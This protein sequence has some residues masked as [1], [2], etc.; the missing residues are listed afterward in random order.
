[1]HSQSS[2]AR[3]ASITVAAL[4]TGYALY[5]LRGILTPLAL[6][7]FL[8]VMVDG[9]ARF[10]DKRVKI[11]PSA[12][13]LPVALLVCGLAL[14]ATILV[15]AGNA[16]A[17]GAQLL[18]AAPRFNALIAQVAGA[19]GLAVPPTIQELV[20]QLNPVAYVGTIANSLQSFAGGAMYVMI[21]LGF[22]IASRQGFEKKTKALFPDVAEREH[23][24][25]IF[26]RIRDG[27]ERYLWIQTVTG[28][29]IALL[30]WGVMAAVGL[31]NSVF[32][33]FVI[34]VV[35]YIPVVG[36]VIAGFLPPLFSLVQFTTL[37]QA[38]V[39]FAGLQVIL[40]AVGNVMLPRMQRDNLNI[41]PVV[42]LLS[43]AVWG[44]LWG[45][46]GMFLSTPLTVMAI[47]ILAQFPGSRWIAVL[48]SGD[49]EPD[50][51]VLAQPRLQAT[52]Q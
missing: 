24:A 37:W 46:P 33:A 51:E 7:L 21:Y 52:P 27:V 5:W 32:W 11:L 17:F 13:A 14:A 39:L 40:F 18:A 15:V 42:V 35:C 19:F 49:G 22:L 26:V 25:A 10:I 6:A 43:L 20:N 1:M 34:F 31:E 3:G 28:A 36:G 16:A 23:A 48:L 50:K 2:V 45:I 30:S 29:A 47:V 12:A 38:V 44:A 4:I 8:M 41:D 9:V